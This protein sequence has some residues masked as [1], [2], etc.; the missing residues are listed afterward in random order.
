MSYHQLPNLDQAFQSNLNTKLTKNSG[1]ANFAELPCNYNRTSRVDRN[2]MY[3]GECRRS[4]VV[5]KAECKDCNMCYIGNTQQKLKLR[6]NQHL[7]EVCNLVNK[8]KT[9]E[10]F[11]KYFTIHQQNRQHKI[12]I[13]EARKKVNVFILW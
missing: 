10:S 4:I 1:S 7:G 13:E 11:T 8:G 2:F 9:S 12:T 3:G 6:I 5:Y